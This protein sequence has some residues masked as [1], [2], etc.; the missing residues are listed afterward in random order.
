MPRPPASVTSFSRRIT[1]TIS[2]FGRPQFPHTISSAAPFNRDILRELEACAQ[3]G[4]LFGTSYSIIDWYHRDF[5]PSEHGGPGPLNDTASGEPSFP[6]SVACMGAQLRELITQYN[7]AVLQ[8]DGEWADAFTPEISAD[9]HRFVRDSNPQILVNSRIDKGRFPSDEADKGSWNRSIYAGD[10]GERERMVAWV[11]HEHEDQGEI[12]APGQGWVTNDRAQWSWNETP[13][14]MTADEIIV[15]LV[16]TGGDNGNYLINMPP[17]PDG[18]FDP[19]QQALRLEVGAWLHRHGQSIY[20]TCGGPRKHEGSYTSTQP[21]DT[22]HLH[23]YDPATTKI[24]LLIPATTKITT[25]EGT[26]VSTERISAEL[27]LLLPEA[28]GNSPVRVSKIQLTD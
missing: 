14:L 10:F 24:E 5:L 4:I 7:P 16:K 6:R 1:T 28:V 12:L 26:S 15:D 18:S 19:T 17:R 25:L 8:F 22:R 11:H 20:H 13:D 23:L 27:R 2:R 9:L 21:G 3:D